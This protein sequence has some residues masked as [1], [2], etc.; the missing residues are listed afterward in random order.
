MF[1]SNN[2]AA[3]PGIVDFGFE[4]LFDR[5]IE[6]SSSHTHP[7]TKV[8]YDFF[9][10]VVRGVFPNT[11]SSGNVVPDNGVMMVN[12]SNLTVVFGKYL[13]VRGR[14]Y[15]AS[16]RF[17]KFNHRMTPTRMS[18][19]ISMKAFY[20]GSVGSSSVGAPDASITKYSTTVEYTKVASNF[21]ES[22]EGPRFIFEPSVAT[23]TGGFKN[24]YTLVSTGGT[25]TEG[26][27]PAGIPRGP[28]NLRIERTSNSIYVNSPVDPVTLSDLQVMNIV[29]SLWTDRNRAIEAWAIAAAE[30]GFRANV[31]GVNDD[32]SI[33]VGL[34][35]INSIN[36]GTKPVEY[37]T[38][39]WVNA[40]KAYEM[41]NGGSNW[42][43]W[44]VWK[45][46]RVDLAAAREFFDRSS[47]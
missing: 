42:S 43:P 6:V 46:N 15:S 32:G 4:L 13:A 16:V 36:H 10:L 1:G 7:G 8:D 19:S 3:A 31:A 21:E 2:M 9:D 25:I 28:F 38:D 40:L 23:T 27:P 12:P 37:W 29:R 30:S 24:P 11:T 41:S 33:D 35:Q 45:Y 34:F 44:Y 39:P 26:V 20:V 22:K 5:H 18:I 17:E 47:A 14:A